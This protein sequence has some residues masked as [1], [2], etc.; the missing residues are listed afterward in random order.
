METSKI[1]APLFAIALVTAFLPSS[2]AQQAKGP[3]TAPATAPAPGHPVDLVGIRLGMTAQQ[4]AAAVRAANPGFQISNNPAFRFDLLPNVA[5]NEVVYARKTGDATHG[6]ES[7]DLKFTQPPNQAMLWSI[8][9]NKQ[10]ADQERPT[11]ANLI[12]GL[13]E[14][15]G[16]EDGSMTPPAV[17]KASGVELRDAYWIFD[18]NGQ[19]LPRQRAA[20]LAATCTAIWESSYLDRLK[21]PQ[22]PKF[23]N[24]NAANCWEN[25]A[26]TAYFTPTTPGV[27]GP[28]G[29]TLELVV[30]AVNMNLYRAHYEAS[31]KFLR[32]AEQSDI[33][34]Q[35]QKAKQAKPAL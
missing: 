28:A 8:Q 34:Q 15:Y 4:A 19:K 9:R 17:A 1:I 3:N 16:P 25:T 20:Q 21:L 32:Q 30:K 10:Y 24:P 29:L 23:T 22:N 13:R 26:V 27:T 11:V 2:A 35:Q 18:I 14:K 31:E 33:N 5:F 6:Q 7:I 12:A